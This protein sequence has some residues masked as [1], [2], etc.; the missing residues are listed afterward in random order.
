MDDDYYQILGVKRGASSKE[1]DKA[2]RDLARKHHPDLNQNDEVAKEKFQQ[3]QAAYDVLNDTKKREMYDRYGP[4]FESMAEG[5]PRQRGPVADFD[6]GQIFGQQSGSG[7][8]DFFEQFTRSSGSRGR[9]RSSRS[10][11]GGSGSDIQQEIQ[12]PF[13]LAVTGGKIDLNLHQ[14]ADRDSIELT[15]QPGVND[16]SKLRVR[17]QGQ[18]GSH[19]GPPGDLYV[20]VRVDSHPFFQREHEDLELRLPITFAEAVNG[21][22]IDVPTPHGEIT[23]SIPPGTSSGKRLRVRGQGIQ[24]PDVRYGDL[25]V[26]V[27]IVVPES[28]DPRSQQLLDELEQLIPLRPREQLRW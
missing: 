18:P 16:G 19:G 26:E 11:P 3:V 23:L 24:R 14:N 21:A 8:A 1:V 13:K 17:G 28:L 9:R 7:A 25:F 15:I 10:S 12:I 22:R 6:L 4:E 20:V 5:G 27:Q 2:Y